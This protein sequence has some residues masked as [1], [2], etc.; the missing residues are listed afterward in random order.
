MQEFDDLYVNRNI[1]SNEIKEW[2]KIPNP[3][4]RLLSLVA[5]TGTGKSWFM[6]ALYKWLSQENGFLPIWLNLSKITDDVDLTG[7]RPFDITSESDRD[8]WLNYIKGKATNQCK[9]L[10]TV[11]PMATFP[12]QFDL[13]IQDLCKEC[14]GITPVLLVDGY[15]EIPTEDEREYLLEHI[16]HTF[17]GKHCTRLLITRR[18]DKKIPHHILSYDEAIVIVPPFAREERYQQ[19]KKRSTN[20]KV[21]KIIEPY[22]SGNP[23]INSFLYDQVA[24][25]NPIEINQAILTRCLEALLE[26]AGLQATHDYRDLLVKMGSQLPATW[27][28]RQLRQEMNLRLEEPEIEA[29]FEAGFI[30]NIEKTPHYQIDPDLYNLLQQLQELIGAAQD[31]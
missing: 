20:D 24:R 4:N 8:W 11:H 1:F 2:L 13:L 5:A 7:H 16:L 28:A 18:D 9:K 19:I 22:L 30:K 15:D 12:T 26:R 25:R 31:E 3:N 10:T 27:T 17:L 29:L 6:V 14:Q 21:N 23:W